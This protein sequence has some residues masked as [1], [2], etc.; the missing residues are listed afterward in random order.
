MNRSSWALC[1]V[2]RPFG[3]PFVAREMYDTSECQLP[4]PSC[5]PKS[6]YERLYHR[7]QPEG[8]CCDLFL[9]G[10][11]VSEVVSGAVYP[12]GDLFFFGF[13]ISLAENAE[14][15]DGFPKI[16]RGREFS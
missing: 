5:L 12:Y 13:S 6:S 10:E 15:T 4:A 8:K 3:I 11:G 2:S 14:V 7:V 16:I 1:L 9:D